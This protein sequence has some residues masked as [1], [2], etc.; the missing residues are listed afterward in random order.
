MGPEPTALLM[1]EAL[2]FLKP[3]RNKVE[4]N[5]FANG[6]MASR[7][8]GKGLDCS[9]ECSEGTCGP[10]AARGGQ[11]H[12]LRPPEGAWFPCDPAAGRA[13]STLN[14]VINLS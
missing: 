3:R 1:P 9:R 14:K 8:E 4:K 10:V 6:S 7:A 11:N 5:G 13:A 12:L 2:L